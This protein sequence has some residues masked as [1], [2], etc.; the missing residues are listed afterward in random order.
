MFS[1]RVVSILSVV[2]LALFIGG[3]AKQDLWGQKFDMDGKWWKKDGQSWDRKNNVFMTVGYSNP[4]WTEEFDLRRSSDLDARAQ[5]AAFM[6]SLVDNYMKE[7]RSNNFAVSESIVQASAKETI[8]GSVI[9][10][11]HYNKAKNKYFSLIKVDM[12]YFF[13]TIYDEY[14]RNVANKIRKKNKKLSSEELDQK[15]INGTESAVRALEA[16]ETPVIEETMQENKS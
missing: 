3:C 9:V 16:I 14:R 5:V 6:Q 4:D 10:A 15:I 8:L 11:R 12:N 7:V 1:R 2:V 13:N